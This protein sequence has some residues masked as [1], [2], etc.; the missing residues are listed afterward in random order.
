MI[1]LH[2]GQFINAIFFIFAHCTKSVYCH[3]LTGH[4]TSSDL[5]MI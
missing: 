5:K 2:G 4:I 1:K 3:I